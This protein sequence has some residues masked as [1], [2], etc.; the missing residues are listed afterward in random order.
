VARQT[1]LAVTLFFLVLALPDPCV[2]STIDDPTV[3]EITVVSDDNYPPY[4]FR[5]NNGGDIQGI[6]VDQWRLWEEKT[7]IHVHLMAMDWGK[8]L[9]T[10]EQG[11]ADA[12]DTIFFTQARAKIFDYGKPYATIDV[13]IFFHDTI[14][15]IT[16]IKSLFGFR[17]GVKRGDACIDM[18]KARG[19]EKGLVEFD[20]YEDIV[21]EAALGHLRVFCIDK[22]PAFYFLNKYNLIHNYH[23]S[24]PLYSGQ[25]HRAVAKGNKA[26]LAMVED[27][28][29]R[30]SKAEYAAIERK[31]MGE[32]IPAPLYLK[33]VWI[34]LAVGGIC[35][36]ILAA[37]SILLRR[38][39]KARTAELVKTNKLLQEEI[40]ERRKADDALRESEA[41]YR[42]LAEN[43]SDIIFTVNMDLAFT[44]ISPSVQRIRGF[45]VEEALAQTFFEILT[46]VSLKTAIEVFEEELELEKSG[47]GNLWRT[48]VLEL[49]LT[50]KDESTIWTETMFSSLR[51]ADERLIGFLGITRDI[52][53]RKKEAEQRALLET[54]LMESQRLESL[55]TL[56]GG[57]AH[58]FNNL[59]AGILGNVSL[60]CM[61]MEDTDSCIERLKNVEEYVKRGSDLTRQLLGFARGGMYEAKPTHLG[62]LLRKSSEMFARTRKEVAI[63]FTCQDELSSVEADRA[64][65]E[66]VLLNLYM[67]AWQAMPEG[68]EI[69]LDLENVALGEAEAADLGGPPGNYVKMSVKDTGTGMDEQTM[70]RIFEPFFTTKDRG[71]GTGLG[72]ASVYGIVR[73]HSGF[74]HVRSKPGQGSTFDIFVPASDKVEEEEFLP[75]TAIHKGYETLLL[76]DDE[77]MIRD[78]GSRMLETMGYKV[79]TA[80]SGQ[81]GLSIYKENRDGI[82][83]VILDMIMP[84]L[85]GRETFEALRSMNPSVK[86][87]LASGYSLDSHAKEIMEQG[88]NGFIQKPFTME[89]LSLKIREVLNGTPAKIEGD[90]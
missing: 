2:A 61:H 65:M 30:I 50:C 87:L 20:S 16:G 68:G 28:F 88:C 25:F 59:L 62:R 41:R 82:A 4:I 86:V 15:G 38:Q 14:S 34:V 52:T 84:G 66:Q 13:P 35:L 56:A 21:K 54:R 10:M 63:H 77:A 58:D 31:W 36:L 17:I 8:A 37:F 1:L 40:S 72:L 43:A 29:S 69:F 55:G 74:I 76:V 33:Y 47:S 48:R 3:R 46:P 71:R 26:M 24:V 81:E 11:R 6:L 42:L 5:D 57:I 9:E 64:Q 22:P 67:N 60:V 27:G 53:E 89:H 19:I 44:Y 75:K 51:D 73:N 79:L 32:T 85:G 80:S 49:E 90:Q 45:T 39:V 23:Y 18:F 12:I 7:G 78:I 83:L 70:T